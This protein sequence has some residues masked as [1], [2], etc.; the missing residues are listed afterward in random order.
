MSVKPLFSISLLF[1]TLGTWSKIY[2]TIPCLCHGFTAGLNSCCYGHVSLHLVV[3]LV[4]FLVL[5]SFVSLVSVLLLSSVDRAF[6][7]IE[8]SYFIR[9]FRSWVHS[10][11]AVTPSVTRSL[12]SW[13]VFIL[14][15]ISSGTS[16]NRSFCYKPLKKCGCDITHS[17]TMAIWW[18]TL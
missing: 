3:V 13:L 10:A 2:I 18:C 5:K 17:S 12:A 1:H 4:W 6:E 14:G 9:S 8:G 7:L 15:K 11:V 16:F